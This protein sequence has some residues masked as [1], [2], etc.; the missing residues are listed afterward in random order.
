MKRHILTIAAFLVSLLAHAQPAGN[1]APTPLTIITTNPGT[2]AGSSI[3]ISDS[4]I[5]YL[6][7]LHTTR[8]GVV[9]DIATVR[10]KIFATPWSLFYDRL[11]DNP[12]PY[13]FWIQAGIRNDADSAQELSLAY[14]NLDFVDA[15]LIPA[16]GAA[17]SPSRG[18]AQPAPGAP[19]AMS[20]QYVPA[21]SLRPPPS[22]SSYL[23][24]RSGTIP[25]Q[26]PPHTG[27]TLLVRVRQLTDD[28]SFDGFALYD[29]AS[30]SAGIVKDQVI[31]FA[32]FV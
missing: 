32:Y 7:S 28:Y 27:A 19:Q 9:R 24:R 15:W 20:P 13:V 3:V 22:G 18:A 4:P 6:D 10:N 30:L 23:Q 29:Q 11:M 17:S 25:L 1:P 5:F 26:L 12:R 21:G 31:A 14:G 2:G 8:G 16:R